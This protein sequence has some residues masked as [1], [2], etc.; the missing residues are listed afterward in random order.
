MGILALNKIFELFYPENSTDDYINLAY[1]LSIDGSLFLFSGLRK[2]IDSNALGTSEIAAN[3]FEC[4]KNHVSKHR[5]AKNIFF[6]IDGIKP[7]N[8]LTTQLNRSSKIK[9][10][11]SEAMQILVDL[12]KNSSEVITIVKCVKGESEHEFFTKRDR[13]MCNVL[14]TNDT[15]LFHIAY[16]FAPTRPE[17]I[18]YF[19][20]KGCKSTYQMNKLN[21]KTT[22]MPRLAFTLL[23]FL[24]G[25]DYTPSSFTL[26]MSQAVHWAF[27]V[28]LRKPDGIAVL[29]PKMSATV[30]KIK[31]FCHT[32]T[33]K[34]KCVQLINHEVENIP[35]VYDVT[36]IQYLIIEFLRLLGQISSYKAFPF[37][38]NPKSSNIDTLDTYSI[39]KMTVDSLQ[40][41]KWSVNYSLIGS[42]YVRFFERNSWVSEVHPILFYC[43]ILCN[44]YPQF[45][46]YSRL[47]S[48][49]KMIEEID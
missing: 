4:I 11:T 43:H 3:A 7:Q 46:T 18:V 44:K 10:D 17:D 28:T 33:E 42:N 14:L 34:E 19:T 47:G 26:T 31:D 5:G 23:S 20:K 49:R 6:Y 41:L 37:T 36:S 48:F 24:Q 45:S 38:L 8:K 9:F 16:D 39:D 12:I 27:F 21:E 25:S 15:D 40:L 29:Y 32:F 22:N 1:N 35:D 2:T 13:T 30:A